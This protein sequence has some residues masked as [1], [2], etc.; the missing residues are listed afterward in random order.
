MEPRF[1]HDF[2]RVRVHTN[3][4]AAESA[5][6]VNALAYTVGRNVVF[7]T[8][9]YEPGTGEGRRLLA[10]ELTHVAQQRQ[11]RTSADSLIVATL[12]DL[13]EQEADAT[14]DRIFNGRPGGLVSARPDPVLRRKVAVAKPQEM[15]PNPGGKG[16]VQT[17]AKTVEDYLTTL[18]SGGS[19]T[20]DKRTGALNIDKSFCEAGP[21]TRMGMAPPTPSL[22]P[23]LKTPT[24]CECLCDLAKSAHLWKIKV[25]D[26][27]DRPE[28]EYNDESKASK[29]GTG[30]I[31]TGGSVKVP[32]PNNPKLWGAGTA[33]GKALVVDPWLILGHELCGHA[34]LANFGQ[35]EA[36]GDAGRGMGGHQLTVAREN[37]L[38]KEH[39]IE[40]RAT[41]REPNCGETFWQ[42]KK[43]S[44]KV[45][46]L[47]FRVVCEKWRA[48]Y[49]K[50]HGTTYKITDTIP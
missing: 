45:N 5:E 41:F 24:G 1:G 15:I 8:G 37:E 28:T 42:D 43:G 44:A 39:G 3:T 33:S 29:I 27:A 31:G 12:G 7:G 30:E 6:A 50:S 21:L 26:A 19:L 18:C 13:A 48:N 20:I 14:A 46:W 40:L 2:G 23:H 17:N 9:R 35:H 11:A 16:L 4:R 34:W 47:H 32:S 38:R 22:A 36:T 49:N 25:D 10:H